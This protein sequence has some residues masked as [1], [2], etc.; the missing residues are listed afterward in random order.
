M[1]NPYRAPLDAGPAHLTKARY[2][3]LLWLCLGALLAYVHRNSISVVEKP[4]RTELGLDEE[5][6]GVVLAA[7]SFTYALLQV[8]AGWIGNVW[9]TRRSMFL[10]SGIW[11]MSTGMMMYVAGLPSLV[12]S[13]FGIGVGQAGLFPCVTNSIRNWF[14]PSQWGMANGCVGC[15]MQVGGVGGVLVSG[16]LVDR[17]GWRNLFLLYSIPGLVWTVWFYLW[18]RDRPEQHGGV[19]P[20]ELALIR[21]RGPAR[22]TSDPLSSA[23]EG[24]PTVDASLPS[25]DIQ[26]ES[27]VTEINPRQPTPWLRILTSVPLYWLCAQQFFRA[28]GYTFFATW[29]GTFLRNTPGIDSKMVGILNSMPLIGAGLGGLVGGTVSDR[30]LSATG[31]RRVARQGISIASTLVCGILIVPAYFSSN[32]WISV[33]FISLGAFCASLAGPAAYTCSMELGGKY[34]ATVFAIMNM[35]GNFG[36]MLFAWL[37]GRYVKYTGNWDHVLIA[38]G[39]IHVA[40]A[41]CWAGFNPNRKIE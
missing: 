11:T 29:F 22:N 20:Q 41:I 28:A 12:A 39:V 27:A 10:Y 19:G 14:N 3:V 18:F 31:S 7:F 26:E 8:P 15:F 34:T 40:A 17:I 2:K 38:F 13:R 23:Y 25:R 21:G 37:T 36:A 33:L 24:A 1:R 16:W 35:M 9:G 30:L 32:L 5:E 6:M 4:M